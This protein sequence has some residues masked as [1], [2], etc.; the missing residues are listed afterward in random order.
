MDRRKEEHATRVSE[1]HT[2][3]LHASAQADR[4]FPKFSAIE[5]G[6]DNQD[7]DTKVP[8]VQL[9]HIPNTIAPT[10]SLLTAATLIDATE[11]GITAAAG[12]RLA[13]Q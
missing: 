13:L 9:L 8:N 2:Q 5:S 10:A 6:T 12:T 7:G 4:S 11:A 1:Q 3:P